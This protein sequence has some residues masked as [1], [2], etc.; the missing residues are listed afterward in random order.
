MSD[1]LRTAALAFAAA[2]TA[3]TPADIAAQDRPAAA[4]APDAR[5]S[6]IAREIIAIGMPEE[7]R[8]TVFAAT[9]DQM[10]RQMREAQR[11]SGIMSED[12]QVEAIIDANLAQ[13]RDEAMG[14]LRTHLPAMMEGWALAYANTFSHEDL[15]AIREFV[16]TP[17]GQRF[18]QLSPAIAAEPNFAAANQLYM[19]DV[20]AMLPALQ[21]RLKKDIV[22][23]LEAKQAEGEIEPS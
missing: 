7:D 19:N 14:V 17:A 18:F 6:E 1:H 4:A 22:D 12:P 9:M 15:L 8:E 16:R 10:L 2:L 3:L 21:A 13:F 23:Y 11:K 5:S 20:M